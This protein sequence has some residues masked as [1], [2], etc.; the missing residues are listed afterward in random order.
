MFRLAPDL[1]VQHSC[2]A[3]VLSRT[4]FIISINVFPQTSLVN[5]GQLPVSHMLGANVSE[6]NLIARLGT[7][8]SGTD[9]P[10]HVAYT[11]QDFIRGDR[12]SSGGFHCLYPGL[13]CGCVGVLSAGFLSGRWGW[14][15]EVEHIFS[16]ELDPQVRAFLVKHDAPIVFEDPVHGCSPRL[17]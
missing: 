15:A 1:V 17:T 4:V 9:I 16:C 14:E 8:C 13:V 2:L 5:L 12:K 7:A 3:R 6:A 10:V 11:L